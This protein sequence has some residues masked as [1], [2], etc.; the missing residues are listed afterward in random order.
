MCRSKDHA[1]NLC[2]WSTRPTHFQFHKSL[3][4]QS[5]TVTERMLI[6]RKLVLTAFSVS[7]YN[8]AC[9]SSVTKSHCTVRPQSVRG[10]GDKQL[11]AC[12]LPTIVTAQS[13]FRRL[14]TSRLGNCGILPRPQS[15]PKRICLKP[16]GQVLKNAETSNALQRLRSK[17]DNFV[18]RCW[19]RPFE[20]STRCFLADQGETR[21]MFASPT[22]SLPTRQHSRQMTHPLLRHSA[23]KV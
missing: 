7:P 15:P 18:L 17:A 11:I 2:G 8:V 4:K 5:V 16:V 12:C 3:P 10:G 22:K 13:A 21:R 23:L 6:H 19:W 1:S 9:F 20:R 14:G